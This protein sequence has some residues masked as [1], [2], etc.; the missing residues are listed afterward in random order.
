MLVDIFTLILLKWGY[1]L[2]LLTVV[3]VFNKICNRTLLVYYIHTHCKYNLL[4]VFTHIRE[5]VWTNFKMIY[6]ALNSDSQF[7]LQYLCELVKNF[8]QCLWVSTSCGK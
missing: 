4:Y 5:D 2:V 7:I 8:I 6:W 3:I 1:E